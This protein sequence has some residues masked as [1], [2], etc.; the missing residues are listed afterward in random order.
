MRSALTCGSD[1]KFKTALPPPQLL[2]RLM[3]MDQHYVFGPALRNANPEM[4]TAVQ[5][6]AEVVGFF[7]AAQI[8]GS[9]SALSFQS[10]GS[11]SS[12]LRRG[13]SL[14]STQIPRCE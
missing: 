4:G 12:Q 7:H 1:Q 14:A 11:H 10:S 8:H 6:R 9:R 13:C 2:Q 5:D 3:Q